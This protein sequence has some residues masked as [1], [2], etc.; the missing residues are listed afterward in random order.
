MKKFLFLFIILFFV[1]CGEYNVVQNNTLNENGIT[2]IAPNIYIKAIKVKAGTGTWHIVYVYCDAQG[3][4]LG[5][6]PISN[7]YGRGK[8][9][10]HIT[11]LN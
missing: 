3:T 1:G 11:T 7:N 6:G 4:P 2:L 10:M 9:D 8:A 5:I